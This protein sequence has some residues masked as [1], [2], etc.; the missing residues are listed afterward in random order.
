MIVLKRH[1][2]KT[3]ILHLI[4]KCD[5]FFVLKSDFSLCFIGV[6]LTELL[7]KCHVNRRDDVVVVQPMCA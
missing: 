5:I 6:Y 2:I 1:I 3:N 7:D 4:K